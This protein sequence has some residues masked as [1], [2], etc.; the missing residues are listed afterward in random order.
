MYDL[1]NPVVYDLEDGVVYE[2]RCY[3]VHMI[4]NW[5]KGGFQLRVDGKN[6]LLLSLA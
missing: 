3:Q 5:V 2:I 4:A 6:S 1:Q